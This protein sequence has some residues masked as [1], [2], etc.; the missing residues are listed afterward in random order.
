ME[1]VRISSRC[2]LMGVEPDPKPIKD[3]IS[4]R[5]EAVVKVVSRDVA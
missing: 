2:D 1:I 4:Q 5:R 3:E